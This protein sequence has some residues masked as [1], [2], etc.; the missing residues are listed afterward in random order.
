MDENQLRDSTSHKKTPDTS[1]SPAPGSIS[2]ALSNPGS[3]SSALSNSTSIYSALSSPI[4]ISSH[5]SALSYSSSVDPCSLN[6][7]NFLSSVT[8]NSLESYDPQYADITPDQWSRLCEDCNRTITLIDGIKNPGKVCARTK[9]DFSYSRP[10]TKDDLSFIWYRLFVAV[11]DWANNIPQFRILSESD[12]AQLMR[13]NF[14]TLSV[15]VYVNFWTKPKVNLVK[16]PMGNGSYVDKQQV[17]R[18]V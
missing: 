7:I 10:A 17:G 5:T 15:I 14:T 2:S 18:H 1:T 9:L 11:A 3:I 12:Q 13:L 8:R 16:L 6:L 4:S